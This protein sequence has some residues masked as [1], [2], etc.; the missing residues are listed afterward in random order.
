M[1]C[2]L[3]SGRASVTDAFVGGLCSNGQI[4]RNGLIA[5][6]NEK[7]LNLRVNFR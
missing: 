4:G 7:S 5:K 1:G 6:F 3:Q 2:W